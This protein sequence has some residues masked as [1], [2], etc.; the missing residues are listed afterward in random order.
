M[1]A[2]TALRTWLRRN[3]KPARIRVRMEDGEE[4]YIEL[5][6]GQRHRWQTVETSVLTSGA[7][8]VECLDAKGVIIRAQK[9]E[10]TEEV[11]G[12]HERDRLREDL[13]KETRSREEVVARERRELGI[14]L[15]RYG[16]RLNEAFQ[17]GAEAA[18]VSQENLVNLVE[19]LTAHLSMAITNL[20]NVSVNL[21]NI[22]QSQAGDGEGN[23]TNNE[24]L[25]KVLGLV[26]A[27]AMTTG[28]ENG[29]AKKGTKP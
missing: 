10:D 12:D 28:S 3:P 14:V 8:V 13:T 11:R 16:D 9:I 19:A 17:R 15:D 23:A 21:A 27:K 29:A 20:H 25:G 18:G 4:R 6:A 1:S 7:E 22:V 5:P 26:A 2:S 24:L